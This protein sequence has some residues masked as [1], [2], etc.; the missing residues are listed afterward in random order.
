M[1]HLSLIKNTYDKYKLFDSLL[2]IA[3]I[4]NCAAYMSGHLVCDYT[5]REVGLIH[6][7]FIRRMSVKKS[8]N[9]DGLYG[10]TNRC[11]MLLIMV[12]N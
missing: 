6:C 9:I 3:S 1:N 12:D 5:S 8:K 11:P 10:E 7:K 2:A 4:L